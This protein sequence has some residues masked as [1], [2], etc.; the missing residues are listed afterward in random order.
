MESLREQRL[1]TVTWG[2]APPLPLP[3]REAGA[4]GWKVRLRWLLQKLGEALLGP[5]TSA[6]FSLRIWLQV[7]NYTGKG[8]PG[9]SGGVSAS[10]PTVISLKSLWSKPVPQVLFTFRESHCVLSP[11]MPL[12]PASSINFL[13]A[14]HVA[15]TC[16]HPPQHLT[17]RLPQVRYPGIAGG[18]NEW[19][20]EF[21][22]AYGNSQ[23]NVSYFTACLLTLAVYLGVFV[24]SA[25]PPD[26]SKSKNVMPEG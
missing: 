14:S 24:T 19:M 12:L 26:F 15:G 16:L 2:V 5:E 9:N 25:Y 7:G 11:K 1:E 13:R 8:V 21:S 23:S 22:L 4:E 10:S 17:P 6:P 18:I 3:W 20:H